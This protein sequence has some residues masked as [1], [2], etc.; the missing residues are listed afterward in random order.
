V[1]EGIKWHPFSGVRQ[2]TFPF[3]VSNQERNKKKPEE[4]EVED[5]KFDMLVP[6]HLFMPMYSIVSLFLGFSLEQL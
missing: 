1:L 5:A 3:L 4:E 6:F 2:A